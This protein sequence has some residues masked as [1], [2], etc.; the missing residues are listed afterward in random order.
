MSYA[1]WEQTRTRQD[2]AVIT[3][4]PS[5]AAPSPPDQPDQPDQPD[6]PDR[7]AAKSPRRASN[8]APVQILAGVF[9]IV[10]IVI[11]ILG[12]VPKI[13]TM[14]GDF[15]LFG[16]DSKSELLGLFQVSALH[17]VVHLLFGV[18]VLAAAR[19]ATARLYLVVGGGLYLVIGLFGALIDRSSSLNFLPFNRADNV[20]HFG[21]SIA[22][23]LLG[24]IGGLLL[25]RDGAT[26]ANA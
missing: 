6:R 9:G 11:G 24:V 8:V 13:T 18:G 12:F 5:P 10:F 20:L 22:M 4:D 3:A 15:G 19:A 1:Y 25:G 7:P 14:F 23:I 26:K 16:R 21:L 17:N 2:E